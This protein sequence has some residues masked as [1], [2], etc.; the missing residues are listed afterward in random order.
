MID[1]K[2]KAFSQQKK[3]CQNKTTYDNFE[4]EYVGFRQNYR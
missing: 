4:N 3:K 1:I 2:D